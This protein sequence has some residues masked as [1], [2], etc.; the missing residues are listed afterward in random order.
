MFIRQS[1]RTLQE[2]VKSKTTG[3]I[4]ATYTFPIPTQRLFHYKMATNGA[5]N[6]AAAVESFRTLKTIIIAT[7]SSRNTLMYSSNR[8]WPT[9]HVFNA[10]QY[11]SITSV[12]RRVIYTQ[13]LLQLSIVTSMFNY[14]PITNNQPCDYNDLIERRWRAA[15]SRTVD[16]IATTTHLLAVVELF[17]LHDVNEHDRRSCKNTETLK[18]FNATS[19]L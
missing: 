9:R 8:H 4:H 18:R 10:I 7:A 12:S 2:G 14:Y 6:R 5:E 17:E 11:I 16:L 13:A 19:T 15:R 1:M 3:R